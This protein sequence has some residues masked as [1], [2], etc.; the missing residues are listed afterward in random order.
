MS[1]QHSLL[2][3]TDNDDRTIATTSNGN[4]IE[5]QNIHATGTLGTEIDLEKLLAD[6]ENADNYSKQHGFIRIDYDT[7]TGSIQLWRTG[8]YTITGINTIPMLETM[9]TRFHNELEKLGVSLDNAE[10]AEIRNYI[11]TLDLNTD[12]RLNLNAISI[13]FGLENIEYEPEQFPGVIYRPPTLDG[14][15]LIFASGSVLLNSVTSPDSMYDLAEHTRNRLEEL[16]L[17]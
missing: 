2:D 3:H 12:D 1:T 13:A 15:C 9:E 10:T 6:L 7:I 17:L 4:P 8:S 11:A 5:T 14:V 16:H